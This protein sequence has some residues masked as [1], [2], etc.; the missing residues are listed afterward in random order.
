MI[1]IK[2][3]SVNKRKAGS[4]KTRSAF[5]FLSI[6]S[7]LEQLLSKILRVEYAEN[8]IGAQGSR[9]NMFSELVRN[10]FLQFAL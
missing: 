2:S 7:I 5:L 6:F 1:G 3:T 10:Y 4:M 9:P 8:K